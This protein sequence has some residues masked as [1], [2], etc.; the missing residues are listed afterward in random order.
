MRG[1]RHELI[2]LLDARRELKLVPVQHERRLPAWRR[3]DAAGGES[4]VRP[5]WVQWARIGLG[6]GEEQR[7]TSKCRIAQPSRESTEYT[8]LGSQTQLRL[9]GTSAPPEAPEQGKARVRSEP[10][11][12]L[13]AVLTRANRLRLR[14]A[15]RS[16]RRLRR[17]GR[18]RRRRVINAEG[19]EAPDR[20]ANELIRVPIS[21]GKPRQVVVVVEPGHGSIRIKKVARLNMLTDESAMNGR[22]KVLLRVCVCPRGRV[23]LPQRDRRAARQAGISLM[24]A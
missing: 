23:Y 10:S 1:A 13:V 22:A 15:P 6:A 11:N 4:N 19:G 9:G 14:R 7:S 18:E 16:L 17:H 20:R 21:E 5:K 12:G 24:N 2:Y 8:P 3:H